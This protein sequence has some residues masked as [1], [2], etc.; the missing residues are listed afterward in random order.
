ME[1]NA[2]CPN[3]GAASKASASGRRPPVAHR[4]HGQIDIKANNRAMPTPS[5]CSR[6]GTGHPHGVVYGAREMV[7]LEGQR[8][9]RA[10]RRGSLLSGPA[11]VNHATGSVMLTLGALPDVDTAILFS[12]ATPVNY[13]NRSNQPISI[14]KSA[15]QLPHTGITPRA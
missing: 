3:Y 12:W 8:P 11:I 10:V 13:T 7:R 5:P 15:W 9:R 6:P 14:S 4:R 1:F 2:Q